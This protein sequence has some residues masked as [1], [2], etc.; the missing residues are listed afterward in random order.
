[1]DDNENQWVSD[2]MD[3]ITSPATGDSR[4]HEVFLVDDDAAVRTSL[5]RLLKSA[6]LSVQTFESAEALLQEA[7][8]DA[9]S[10]LLLDVR[11]PG[12]DGISLQEKLAERRC[13]VPI[14]FL[15]AFACTS[16]VVHAMKQGANYFLEKPIDGDE[17]LTKVQE[18]IREWDITRQEHEVVRSIKG[19]MARLTV[20][21]Q[22]V[23]E[24]VVLGKLNKQIAAQLGISE[25]TVKV[26]RAHG[27]QKLGVR[28]VADLVR[29]F[30]KCQ[31]PATGDAL[32]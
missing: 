9:G 8:L 23:L 14:I 19:R 11:L 26:H 1:M 31:F 32:N 2:F 4:Q 12:I 27:L 21:E 29:L 18:A 16:M 24:Q 17:L 6:G 28:T 25:K 22:A 7:D 30:E 20:R 3:G 13:H 15:T 5:T 10:C